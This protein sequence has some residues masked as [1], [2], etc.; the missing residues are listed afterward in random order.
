MK[1]VRL[2]RKET[3][4]FSSGVSFNFLLN[5]RNHLQ[6]EHHYKIRRRKVK[7][8]LFGEAK[9]KTNKVQFNLYAP[10]AKRVFLVGDF[11]NWD[12]NHLPMKKANK[13]TWETSFA[14]PPGRHEYRFWV[15]GVWYDDPNAQERVEN[16]FGSQNCVRLIS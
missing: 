1:R 15:D 4:V 13:G 5:F 9:P 2:K 11:N 7:K 10:E 3:S 12:A 6:T 14:L 16:P 8:K